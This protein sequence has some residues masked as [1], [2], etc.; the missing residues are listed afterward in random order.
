MAYRYQLSFTLTKGIIINKSGVKKVASDLASTNK[1]P[2]KK[3]DV[4]SCS[5]GYEIAYICAYNGDSVVSAEGFNLGSDGVGIASYS[6]KNA[7]VTHLVLSATEECLFDD[8]TKTSHIYITSSTPTNADGTVDKQPN[9]SVVYERQ[10]YQT[11]MQKLPSPWFEFNGVKNTEVGAL[12]V[13]MPTRQHPALRGKKLTIAGRDGYI[14]QTDGT[15][16]EIT[17]KQ[18]IVVPRIEDYARVMKWLSGYGHLIFLMNLT[19]IT[20][21]R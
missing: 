1:F 8:A 19:N 7:S 13:S 10:G 15:Y 11:R 3:G 16:G 4:I 20:R 21:Q 6:V 5:S 17:V 12:M 2:V 9:G 18:D 14:Y